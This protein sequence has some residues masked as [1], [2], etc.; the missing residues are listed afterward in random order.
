MVIDTC[1]ALLRLLRP[2]PP[3]PAPSKGS[4]NIKVDEHP[5][6]RELKVIA[7]ASNALV[8][9]ISDSETRSKTTVDFEGQDFI[10]R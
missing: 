9:L 3:S 8:E 7:G 2:R 10:D 5:I 4:P 6:A 1:S